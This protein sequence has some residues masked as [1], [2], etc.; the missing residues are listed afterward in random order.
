MAFAKESI[1]SLIKSKKPRTHP[2]VVQLVLFQNPWVRVIGQGFD[3][4]DAATGRAGR[5][6]FAWF[7]VGAVGDG[8]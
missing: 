7:R 8:P 5:K 6:R 1:K 2:R 4:Q 3:S